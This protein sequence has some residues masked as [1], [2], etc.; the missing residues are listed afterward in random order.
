[1][2]SAKLVYD[3]IM[4]KQAEIPSSIFSP[5]AAANVTSGTTPFFS[6]SAGPSVG[7]TFP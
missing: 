1:V 3:K 4:Q 2:I 5:S 6:T 7:L